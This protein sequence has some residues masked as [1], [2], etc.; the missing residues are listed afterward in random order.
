[1]LRGGTSER[2][3][4]SLW[5]TSLNKARDV[6]TQY[7]ISKEKQKAR[8]FNHP[9]GIQDISV[10]HFVLLQDEGAPEAGGWV[11]G[12]IGIQTCVVHAGLEA[13]TWN[14]APNSLQF[15]IL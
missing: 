6:Q 14:K 10:L 3:R 15:Q 2:S 8:I 7:L 5:P 12:H 9:R 1:M 11:G 4:P 13:R